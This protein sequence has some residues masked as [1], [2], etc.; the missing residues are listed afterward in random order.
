MKANGN[1]ETRASPTTSTRGRDRSSSAA[2]AAGLDAAAGR[3]VIPWFS[4]GPPQREP[5]QTR[6]RAAGRRH[7]AASRW[8]KLSQPGH[9]AVPHAH[10]EDALRDLHEVKGSTRIEGQPA[11]ELDGPARS[12]HAHPPRAP[13]HDRS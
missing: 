8:P 2:K 13:E 7:A 12:A 11:A 10:D 1:R 4:A 9:A 6:L 3:A 5:R